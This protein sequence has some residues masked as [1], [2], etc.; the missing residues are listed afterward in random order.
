MAR[1]SHRI[2]KRS[3]G[4]WHIPDDVDLEAAT[5]QDAEWVGDD[6]AI[7]EYLD[8]LPGFD[9]DD[10]DDMTERTGW[11]RRFASAVVGR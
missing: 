10:T 5:D 9:D 4:G 2:K 11:L 8:D 7:D 3:G 1:K 6:D